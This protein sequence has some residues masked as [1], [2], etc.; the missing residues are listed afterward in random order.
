MQSLGCSHGWTAILQKGRKDFGSKLHFLPQSNPLA[1]Q[2]LLQPLPPPHRLF[3][4]SPREKIHKPTQLLL[5]AQILGF[6]GSGP[7]SVVLMWL[8][9]PHGSAICKLKEKRSVPPPPPAHNTQL[10]SKNRIKERQSL[11]QKRE[12][13]KTHCSY[14][15]IADIKCC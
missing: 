8:E 1:F 13:P 9:E 14:Q 6:L 7:F 3:T 10:W 15:S 4:S 12:N 5:L 2:I 11:L